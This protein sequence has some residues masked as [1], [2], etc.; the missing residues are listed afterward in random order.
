LEILDSVADMLCLSCD[1]APF[2][3]ID[4]T[5]KQKIQNS[6]QQ[7]PM[8][9]KEQPVQQSNTHLVGNI[10]IWTDQVLFP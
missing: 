7:H 3:F 8:D 5:N 4:Y 10:S 1:E 2:P 9:L 6:T